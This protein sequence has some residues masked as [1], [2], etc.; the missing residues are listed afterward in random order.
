MRSELETKE[1]AARSTDFD[2]F[3]RA[4]WE[5]MVRFATLTTGSI[6]LAEEIVQD[7]F[8]DVLRRWDRVEQPTGYLRVAV[9]SRCTGWVRRRQIQRRVPHPVPLEQ[10]DSRLVELLEALKVLTPRQRAA[11]VLRYLDDLPESEI[12]EALSCR[13][14]T[15]RSLLARARTKLQEALES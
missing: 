5:P 15:V 2:A 12:A 3:Y 11:I 9:A 6:A 4:Q 1:T 10:T 8:I 14:G 13:P 7:A